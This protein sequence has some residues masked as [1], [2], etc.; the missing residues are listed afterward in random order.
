MQP[1]RT[2][3]PDYSW[4]QPSGPV[5]SSPSRIKILIGTIVALLLIATLALFVM[6]SFKQSNINVKPISSHAIGGQIYQDKAAPVIDR[7][8][9]FLDYVTLGQ[10]QQVQQMTSSYNKI[11]GELTQEVLYSYFGDSLKQDTCSHDYQQSYPASI[12]EYEGFLY[13]VLEIDFRCEQ[14]NGLV[15]DIAL[16]FNRDINMSEGWKFSHASSKDYG[17]E[18]V[19]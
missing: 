7:A 4:L 14:S 15:L 16:E 9:R 5:K 1:E 10:T 3:I 12:S 19:Y 6:L 13:D 2:P 8:L 18:E 11:D 17:L